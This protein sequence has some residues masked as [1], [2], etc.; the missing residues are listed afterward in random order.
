L[1]DIKIR[2]GMEQKYLNAIAALVEEGCNPVTLSW[3]L[4]LGISMRTKSV[5]LVPAAKTVRKLKEKLEELATE[6]EVLEKSGFLMLIN[7]QETMK[8]W[9]EKRVGLDEVD[10]LGETLPHL[11]LQRWLRKKADMYERW[12]KLAS[13][14]IPPKKGTLLRGVDYLFPAYYVRLVTGKSCVAQLVKL[15]DTVDRLNISEAQLSRELKQLMSDY[16]GLRS[17]MEVM[18]DIVKDRNFC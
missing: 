3:V 2:P 14:R 9:Q 18:F 8:L 16:R 12:L 15:F 10:D 5:P 1:P 6:I 4:R 17:T 7:R 13:D 11:F